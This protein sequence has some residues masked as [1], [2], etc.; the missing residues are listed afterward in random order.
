MHNNCNCDNSWNCT[1][2][3]GN[4]VDINM[5]NS[6]CEIR[7]DVVLSEYKAVRLWGRVVNC[8]GNP[9]ENALI[10]LVEIECDCNH[11]YYKGI[12]H[13]T[14]D[15]DG[16]YQFELCNYD[17][18]SKYKLLVNKVAYGDNAMIPIELNECI[19][20]KEPDDY[21]TDFCDTNNSNSSH[22]QNKCYDYDK[23]NNNYTYHNHKYYSF[24]NK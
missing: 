11:E 16:F 9:I 23:Y 7:A 24:K 14:S 20:C 13:T 12:A 22:K 10:K 21:H 8:E 17:K 19:S 1:L 5:D 15:C 6:E 3:N 2:F 18:N 4:S